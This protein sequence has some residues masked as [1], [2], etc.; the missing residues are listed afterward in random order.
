M[1]SKYR[2]IE[3]DQNKK[4]VAV[5]VTLRLLSEKDSNALLEFE[6]ENRQWFERFIA[7]REASML[8]SEG[9]LEHIE[10]CLEEYEER[11]LLPMVVVDSQGEIL[12]RINFH[13]VKFN[14]GQAALGYRFA[15]RAC[16]KGLA[17]KMIM[18]GIDT[19][20]DIGFRRLVA[21]AAVDN[22]ASQRVLEKCGFSQ[23][24]LV[25][26]YVRLHGHYVDCFRYQLNLRK[27]KNAV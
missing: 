23:V 9:I 17:S 22:L 21:V 8:S 25:P 11:R 24:A 27:L 5:T 10:F 3:P 20:R 15:E 6:L 4:G 16:G 13:D 2:L 18:E 26:N 1:S 12:G 19:V 14:Q 7:P